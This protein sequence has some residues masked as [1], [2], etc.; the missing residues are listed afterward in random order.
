MEQDENER[1]PMLEALALAGRG[2]AT[3]GVF[4][5][6]KAAE[7]YRSVDPDVQRHL[8]QIPMLSYALLS[9]KKERIEAGEPD[10]HPPLIFVHGLGGNEGVFL[11]MAWYF[12]LHGRKRTYRIDFAG[13]QTIGEQ[14]AALARF[15]REV[16][17][18]T[19]EQ[20]VEIV[21]HSLGG[22]IARLAIRRHRLGTS[23]KTLVTMGTPHQGTFPAR[24]ANTEN[25]REL[26]PDSELVREL[27]ELTLPRS[28]RVVTFWSR[29]DLLVLPPEAAVLPGAEQVDM[30][31]FTH[32]SYL[33]DPRGWNAVRLALESG[34]G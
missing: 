30:T 21:A 26:R 20:Q 31:P 25:I 7:I 13:G 33:L 34:R 14:A 2:L 29:N 9:R 5:G 28:V 11:L 1:N 10:G 4:V 12:W 18:V 19:A 16:K 3:A 24:Y 27:K 22:I 8:V 15:V 23:V 17:K 32:Y 6:R